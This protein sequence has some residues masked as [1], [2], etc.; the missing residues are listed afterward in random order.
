M[1]KFGGI[2]SKIPASNYLNFANKEMPVEGRGHNKALNM[3][4]KCV[5]I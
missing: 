5:I 3:S 1:E 4:I 2:I